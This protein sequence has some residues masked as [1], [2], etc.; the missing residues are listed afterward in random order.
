MLVGP[1][2][3]LEVSTAGTG[4]R[5][6]GPDGEEDSGQVEEMQTLALG[7]YH[8]ARYMIFHNRPEGR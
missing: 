3:T 2:R 4:A 8:T 1:E 7:I 5:L 6:L